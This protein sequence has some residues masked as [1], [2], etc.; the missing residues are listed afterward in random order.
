MIRTDVIQV[1]I[2][3]ADLKAIVQAYIETTYPALAG[4]PITIDTGD[5][6]ASVASIEVEVVTLDPVVVPV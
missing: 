1:T 4:K 2:P 3:T 5:L 6:L